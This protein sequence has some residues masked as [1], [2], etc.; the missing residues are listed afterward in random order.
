MDLSNTIGLIKTWGWVVLVAVTVCA[1]VAFGIATQRPR[2]YLSQTSILV[3]PPLDGPVNES[4]LTVGQLLRQTYA[5]LAK[6]R[7][8][9]QRVVAGTGV[10]L[11]PEELDGQVTTSVPSNSGILIISVVDADAARSA[12]LANAV[13]DQLVNYNKTGT[14]QANASNIKLEVVDPAVAP[15]VPEDRRILLTTLM[16]AAVG[17]MIALGLAFIIESMRRNKPAIPESA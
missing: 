5:D 1:L 10:N 17:A 2:T 4:D 7:P 12:V 15:T 11:T 6:T 3:S 14:G 8:L 13:A 9:L 16:G